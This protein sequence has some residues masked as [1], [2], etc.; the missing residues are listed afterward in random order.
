MWVISGLSILFHWSNHIILNT[1]FY[2]GILYSTQKC[3]IIYCGSGYLSL[4]IAALWDNWFSGWRI[5]YS[6]NCQQKKDFQSLH[7][8][9]KLRRRMFLAMKTISRS[10]RAIGRQFVMG[11]H[12]MSSKKI[13]LSC[14][15]CAFES[16]RNPGRQVLYTVYMQACGPMLFPV[17]VQSPAII[18]IFTC[19]PC[20]LLGGPSE[21]PKTAMRDW[22]SPWRGLLLKEEGTRQDKSVQ[23]RDVLSSRFR[24]LPLSL[25]S[26]RGIPI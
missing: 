11:F 14:S 19:H 23:K 4:K 22:G 25:G 9:L 24:W 3:I 26:Q 17:W 10:W 2:S 21:V 20:E 12:L 16:A 13:S 7:I 5:Y 1:I 15:L 8:L 6:T 18:K